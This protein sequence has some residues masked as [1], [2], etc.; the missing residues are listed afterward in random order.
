MPPFRYISELKY[1]WSKKSEIFEK[2]F[3]KVQV[4]YT[5]TQ[6]RVFTYDNTETRTQGYMLVNL[7]IGTGFKSKSGKS[8]IDVYV[9]AN[10]IFDTAYQDHLSRL[11]YF[12]QYSTSPNGRLGIYSMGRNI[13]I[14]LVKNF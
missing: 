8:I 14:K 12:E 13:S 2:P 6:N 1:E 4:Q 3:I 7:G 11:K 5:T 9:L 10:N